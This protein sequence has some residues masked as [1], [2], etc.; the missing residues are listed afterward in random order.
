[1]SDERLKDLQVGARFS[2]PESRF[3]AA[4]FICLG[5]DSFMQEIPP[6]GYVG[7]PERMFELYEGPVRV[8]EAEDQRL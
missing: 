1:M 3:P 6:Y 5:G 4:R 7:Y 8:H 2:F